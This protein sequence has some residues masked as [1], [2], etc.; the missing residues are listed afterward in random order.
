M[1]LGIQN[2]HEPRKRAS[3]D[4]DD[5]TAA[6]RQRANSQASGLRHELKPDSLASLCESSR[7]IYDNRRFG[8]LAISPVGRALDNF[9]TLSKLFAALRD[10]IKVYRSLYLVGQI[11]Y[12][13][14][15]ENSIIITD[16]RML[17]DSPDC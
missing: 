11:L 16:P 17:I 8:C 13:D 10:A 2:S 1:Q 4:D 9:T 15:L 6:K 12:R 14:I 7:D 3:V 5:T